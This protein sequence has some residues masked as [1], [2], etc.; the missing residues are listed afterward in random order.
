MLAKFT[1]PSC[2]M[3][4]LH[5]DEGERYCSLFWSRWSASSIALNF[6]PGSARRKILHRKVLYWRSPV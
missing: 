6:P 2:S 1:N 4:V 5:L 3:A